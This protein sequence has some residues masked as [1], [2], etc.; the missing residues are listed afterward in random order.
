MSEQSDA[1]LS[2]FYSAMDRRIAVMV[3]LPAIFYSYPDSCPLTRCSGKSLLH[4][5]KRLYILPVLLQP[6][7][8]TIQKMQPNQTPINLLDEIS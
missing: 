6:E 2:E 5:L 8:N 3:E 1:A 4:T 7:L